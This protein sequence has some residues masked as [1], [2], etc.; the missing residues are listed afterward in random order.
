MKILFLLYSELNCNSGYHVDIFAAKLV[1][2][3]HEVM[4]VH[5]GSEE[6]S[7]SLAYRTSTHANF[8]ENTA[9]LLREFHPDIVCAWTPREIVRM[10]WE[11]LCKESSERF[12]L[13]IHYEDNEVLL[14]ERCQPEIRAAGSNLGFFDLI[15]G[16]GFIDRADGFTLVTES[17]QEIVPVGGRQFLTVGAPYDDRV[18]CQKPRNDSW[19]HEHGIA[20]GSLVI[21][22]SG[23]VHRVNQEDVGFLYR[24]VDQLASR[25][26]LTLVRT[27]VGMPVEGAKKYLIDLGFVSRLELPGILAAADLFVQ[28]GQPGPFDSYRFPS[29][30][31][32]MA[33]IGRPI[34][35]PDLPSLSSFVDRIEV[36]KC[37]MKGPDDISDAVVEVISTP[38]LYEKLSAAAV[39]AA[40]RECSPG[41]K[42]A[43]LVGFYRKVLEVNP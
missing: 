9:Q 1:E 22:Y 25:M 10:L 23:N 12:K 27:G 28:P 20:E 11:K 7:D 3:G 6:V 33:V 39:V 17:L 40:E 26:P 4:V 24:A 5:A 41:P 31:P 18:F 19:R 13:V 34:I 8:L 36:F 37:E 16:Q 14:A 21:V 32:E 2:L 30:I 38:G 42:A 43:R 35:C 29:K 15:Q